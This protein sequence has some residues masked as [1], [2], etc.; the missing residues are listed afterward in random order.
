MSFNSGSNE[1]KNLAWIPLVWFSFFL[2]LPFFGI[3]LMSFAQKGVYGGVEWQWSLHNYSRLLEFDIFKILV[4]S[5]VLAFVNAMLCIMVGFFCAWAM[6]CSSARLRSLLFI[7]ISLPF[8]TNLIIRIYA[9]KSF[10]G[11]DGPLQNLFAFFSIQIDPFGFTSNTYMVY[12]GMLM[13]YVPFASLPLYAA[14]EKF[15]FQLVEA[16]QDLGAKNRHQLFYVILPLLRRAL[17]SAFFLVFVPSLGEFVIPDLLGGAKTMYLGNLISEQ[18]LKSRDWPFG[19][20][21][22]VGMV[23][24]LLLFYFTLSRGFLIFSKGKKNV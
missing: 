12:L 23:G 8:L 14:L 4:K 17:W 18:F 1:A 20:A 13:T 19:A 10:V 24:I 21:L 3:F 5:F 9:L 22:S 6:S 7:L 11:I 2:T 16:A 15:D